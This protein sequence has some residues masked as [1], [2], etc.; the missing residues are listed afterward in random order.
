MDNDIRQIDMINNN[1]E[2]LTEDSAVLW[3]FGYGSLCWHPGFDY[4]RDLSGHIKG[5]TRRF[6]QGNTVHRGTAEKVFYYQFYSAETFLSHAGIFFKIS[7]E[8]SVI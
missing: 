3:V 2:G 8:V 7:D 1:N 4:K 6:W 5:F